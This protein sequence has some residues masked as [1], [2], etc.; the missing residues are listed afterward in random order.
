MI[1]IYLDAAHAPAWGTSLA[2]KIAGDPLVFSNAGLTAPL[3]YKPI[4]SADL[5]TTSYA[6]QKE[7]AIAAYIIPQ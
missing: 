7:L 5:D 3:L 1:A 2:L 6:A 4:S